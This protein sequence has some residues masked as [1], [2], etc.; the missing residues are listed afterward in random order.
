MTQADL[1]TF[2]S[3][4]LFDVVVLSLVVNF[5]GDPR[6][7]GRMLLAARN[8]L[9]VHESPAVDSAVDSSLHSKVQLS[10]SSSAAAAAPVP[11]LGLCF[12]ILPL[13]CVENSRYLSRPL[14]TVR[15]YLLRTFSLSSSPT[16]VT[17]FVRI[18]PL[19][20]ALLFHRRP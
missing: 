7:R 19:S 16:N 15:S 6:A 13:A 9:K 8:L 17:Y 3:T 1:L 20:N 4:A 2:K 11:P 10:S 12:V 18:Y 14:F 5:E